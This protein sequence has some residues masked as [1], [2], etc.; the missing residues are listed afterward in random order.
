M[1]VPLLNGGP[2]FAG[3]VGRNTANA[4]ETNAIET[5]VIAAAHLMSRGLITTKK[6]DKKIFLA[7]TG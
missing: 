3:K 4:C 5:S 7:V 2:A 1:T 6:A